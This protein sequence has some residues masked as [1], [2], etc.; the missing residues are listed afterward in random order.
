MHRK[1]IL[2]S[3]CDAALILTS[4]TTFATGPTEGFPSYK[5]IKL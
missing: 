1:S 2:K 5:E 4:A 3:A